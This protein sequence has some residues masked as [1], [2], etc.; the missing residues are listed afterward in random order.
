MAPGPTVADVMTREVVTIGEEDNLLEVMQGMEQLQ[1]RHLP[2]VDEDS[3]LVG[4]I[5]Q[6]DLLALASGALGATL[7]QASRERIV[8]ENTF[9]AE[10]MVRDPITV[11]PETPLEEAARVMLEE[12]IGALPVVDDEGRLVGIVTQHD[13]LRLL[14]SVLQTQEQAAQAIRA[15]LP[16]F[17]ALGRERGSVV[18]PRP[19]S[20][21]Q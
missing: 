20:S 15:A 19:P 4:L 6:R 7:L 12:K 13:M 9:V 18:P 14:V 5:T 10:V 2:V 17:E 11:K 8:E 21:G 16:R 3:K 1:V